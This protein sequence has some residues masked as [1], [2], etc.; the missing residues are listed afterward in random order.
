MFYKGHGYCL[1][2]F[3]PKQAIDPD[4]QLRD[5]A[6]MVEKFDHY[7]VLREVALM[8]DSLEPSERRQVMA[9]LAERFGMKLMDKT[10]GSGNS[11]RPH[12]KRKSKPY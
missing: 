3:R 6:R 1:T 7:E 12:Y 2:H 9:S 5:I 4:E 11:F 10:T 8:I